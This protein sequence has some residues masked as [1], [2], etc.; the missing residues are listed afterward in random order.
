MLAQFA[1]SHPSVGIEVHCDMSHNLIDLFDRGDL[2]LVLIKRDRKVKIAGNKVWREP[3]V[4]VGAEQYK[5][6]DKSEV[7]PLI[8]SPVP[9]VFRSTM[10]EALD[11][12]NMPWRAVFTSAS[13]V[14]RIAAA[15]SG[16]GVTA[17]PVEILSQYHGLVSL[18]NLGIFP[19]LKPIDID[20]LYNRDKMNDASRRLSDH[21][22]FALENSPVLAKGGAA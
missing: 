16:L 6:F 7:L 18:D 17:I 9:C 3:L 20:L 13:L 21:I 12:K 10:T 2:D 5:D 8:L 14:G 15:R 19:R 1:K 4:W 11:Q 22:I